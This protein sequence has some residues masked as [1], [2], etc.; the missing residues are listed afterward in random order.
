GC[1]GGVPALYWRGHW[2]SAIRCGCRGRGGRPAGSEEELIPNPKS[3]PRAP[4][5]TGR[6][7][8]SPAIAS[9]KVNRRGHSVLDKADR[10]V[11]VQHVQPR[12]MG[13]AEPKRVLGGLRIAPL[14]LERLPEGRAVHVIVVAAEHGLVV[15]VVEAVGI[16]FDA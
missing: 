1:I 9:A 13:T 2:R 16:V 8:C 7:S 5:A 15:A 11:T 6:L 14:V 4:G 3:W 12:G 10:A